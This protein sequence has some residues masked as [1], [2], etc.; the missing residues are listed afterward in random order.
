LNMRTM[1]SPDLRTVPAVPQWQ[2]HDKVH[3]QTA[4]DAAVAVACTPPGTVSDATL[5][6]DE[7]LDVNIVQI[8]EPTYARAQK[9]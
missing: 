9:S 2:C 8:G 3:T 4:S 6:A 1:A 7:L 5:G